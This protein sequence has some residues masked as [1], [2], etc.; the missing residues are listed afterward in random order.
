MVELY[1]AVRV[2]N[3]ANPGLDG[4]APPSPEQMGAQMRKALTYADKTTLPV[5][6]YYGGGYV[7]QVMGAV[8]RHAPEAMPLMQHWL[9]D[10]A[11]ATVIKRLEFVLAAVAERSPETWAHIKNHAALTMKAFTPLHGPIGEHP[12]EALQALV[13]A[14]G[15]DV[16]KLGIAPELL[17]KHTR[18]A[19][20][21]FDYALANYRQHVPDYP[22]KAHD[23]AF[24]EAAQRGQLVFD[25]QASPAADQAADQAAGPSDAT[26]DLQDRRRAERETLSPQELAR[27]NQILAR[28][29]RY[30]RRHVPE[31]GQGEWLKPAEISQLASARYGTLSPQEHASMMAHDPMGEAYF[32]IQELPA[33]LQAL[34]EIVNMKGTPRDPRT[35]KVKDIVQL[36]DTFEALTADRAYR[37]AYPVTQALD[38]MDAMAREGALNPQLY[39]QFR[40]SG[41]GQAFARDTGRKQGETA[42]VKATPALKQQETAQQPSPAPAGAW[43]QRVHR[44]PNSSPHPGL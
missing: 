35:A 11:H 27:H 37:P 9:Q 25:P 20:R 14:L 43:V 39:Q 5:N 33:P 10:P 32:A 29:D 28:I 16:G 24:L 34:P 12:A 21:R 8:A 36:A 22:Q 2:Y 17:H 44:T 26:I 15:H 3:H 40:Q 13:G 7:H 1:D 30:A 42:Q 41:V 23:L 38:I 4:R 19:P 18:L 6:Y 31:A